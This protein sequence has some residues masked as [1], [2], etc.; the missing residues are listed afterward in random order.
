LEHF[1]ALT[2][3]HTGSAT[4]IGTHLLARRAAIGATV[5]F[6]L[7]TFA[8]VEL[9]LTGSE[10]ELP[11]AVHTIQHFINVHLNETPCNVVIGVV[12]LA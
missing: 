11:S 5:R 8:G 4:G 3:A 6:V 12:R 9:L 10:R 2:A 1:A 7:E